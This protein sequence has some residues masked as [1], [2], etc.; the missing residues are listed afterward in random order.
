[1]PTIEN[2]G[3]LDLVAGTHKL[4]DPVRT[5]LIRILDAEG[6]AEMT[7]PRVPFTD[8]HSFV[9][10]DLPEDDPLAVQYPWKV[11]LPDQAARIV[12]LLNDALAR[13]LDV[14]VCCTAGVARS[15]AVVEVGVSMG[16]SDLK[17]YRSS[18]TR[19][20]RLLTDAAYP[21]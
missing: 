21:N 17:T 7:P 10:L 16:F 2:I 3:V 20:L 8:V 6:E 15:G 13:D 5:R 19:V 18:N 1:M 12:G 14:L 9:F 11:F 4:R